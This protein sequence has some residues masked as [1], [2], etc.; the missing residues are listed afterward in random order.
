MLIRHPS[1]S[2]FHLEFQLNFSTFLIA[3]SPHRYQKSEKE[4]NKLLL[5]L[6]IVVMEPIHLLEYSQLEGKTDAAHSISLNKIVREVDG[7]GE[8]NN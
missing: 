7:K 3:H 8:V 5:L 2:K 1:T 4:N 6:G